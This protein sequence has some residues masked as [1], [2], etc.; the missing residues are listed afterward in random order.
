MFISLNGANEGNRAAGCPLW[1]KSSHSG[2]PGLI[3]ASRQM[4]SFGLKKRLSFR[5]DAHTDLVQEYFDKKEPL[6]V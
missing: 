3:S 5:R 2:P 4:R 1:V 6:R